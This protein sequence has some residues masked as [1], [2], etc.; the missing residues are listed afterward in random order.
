MYLQDNYRIS[1][2][3]ACQT[4]SLSTS[5]W[6]Y[7]HSIRKDDSYL[8]FR[9]REISSDR[10]RYGFWRIFTLVRR[11]GFRD[12]HK[13]V[14][15]IYKE[16][17]LNL[18]SKRHRRHRSS[19]NRVCETMPNHLTHGCWSMDFVSD[20]LFDGRRFRIL[21][22]LDNMT[23][24]CLSL[25]IGQSLKGSD[26]VRILRNVTTN[27]S[28]PRSIQVDNGP[29]FISKDLDMW[30]YD[31][32]V[33]L[34]FSRPGRP[35]DNAFIESFNGSL[36]D[37]CLNIHWFLSLEDARQKI[38]QW[39][40]EY[41]HFRPHMSLDGLTPEEAMNAEKKDYSDQISFPL[42]DTISDNGKDMIFLHSN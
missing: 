29:E 34:L 11:E 39:R 32:N 27:E 12:N 10:V 35:T 22:I 3:R 7:R 13:R 6:Y 9:V 38:E 1:L 28:L 5:S 20:Q 33:R 8:R 25:E 21:T 42:S 36:R 31:N 18:R 2:R 24:R 14:Y 41:N 37:E 40:T 26:V 15:R 16:E 23:R 4:V 17:G 30:A 19:A